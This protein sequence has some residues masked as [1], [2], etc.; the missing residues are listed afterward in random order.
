MLAH[1]KALQWQEL[2]DLAVREEL[3]EDE[4]VSMGYRVAG[5]CVYFVHKSFT[6]HELEDL[7]SKRRY[8]ECA[9]VL[10]DYSKDVREATI[11]LVQGN[12]ISEARRIASNITR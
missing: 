4:I 11:A 5:S 10:L 7:S 8:S 2:F 6:Y 9:R 12:N 1:E 3:P